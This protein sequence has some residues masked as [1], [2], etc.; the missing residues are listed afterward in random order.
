MC[1]GVDVIINLGLKTSIQIK[2]GDYEDFIT[3]TYSAV[4]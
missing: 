1:V 4:S 2:K 3:V